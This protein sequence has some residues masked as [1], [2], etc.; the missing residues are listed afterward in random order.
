MHVL[1]F[2]FLS[3]PP[4][5]RIGNLRI[6]VCF[7]VLIQRVQF[8]NL[9]LEAPTCIPAVASMN[10]ITQVKPR[11]HVQNW[12][13]ALNI[14][15]II[16]KNARQ[17]HIVLARLNCG[18]ISTETN[19]FPQTVWPHWGVLTVNDRARRTTVRHFSCKFRC[20]RP[21]GSC[22][23]SM[24]VSIAQARTKRCPRDWGPAFLVNFKTTWILRDWG[25]AF[26]F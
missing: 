6:S 7:S 24:C 1:Y 26:C 3:V 5:V 4:S 10:T 25:P 11:T 23:M 20:Q 13:T 19:I 18:K 14:L 21:K 17:K 2:Y 15:A 8:S 22:E 9:M 12:K 16:Q